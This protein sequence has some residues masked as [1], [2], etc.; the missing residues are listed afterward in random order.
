MIPAVVAN[1]LLGG[2][3]RQRFLKYILIQIDLIA[4]KAVRESICV[5]APVI[6]NFATQAV[7]VELIGIQIVEMIQIQ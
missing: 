6:S 7:N 2:I 4:G 3:Q 1:M 5:T